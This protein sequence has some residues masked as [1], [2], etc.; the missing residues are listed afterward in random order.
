[1]A[2]TPTAS[3]A[4]TP[5]TATP[6]EELDLVVPPGEKVLE[7][8]EVEVEEVGLGPVKFLELGIKRISESQWNLPCT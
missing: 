7:D 5:P 6:T 4:N 3:P 1:V 8:C 2:R